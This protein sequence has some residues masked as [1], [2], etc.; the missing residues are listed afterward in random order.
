MGMD[1][2]NL[3]VESQPDLVIVASA[4][5]VEGEPRGVLQMRLSSPG[6]LYLKSVDVKPGWRGQGIGSAMFDAALA[7]YLKRGPVH[8]ISAHRATGEVD[9]LWA[10]AKRRHGKDIRFYGDED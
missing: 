1:D 6:S 5:S 10:S 2:F 3:N 8:S 4:E 9:G 7:E